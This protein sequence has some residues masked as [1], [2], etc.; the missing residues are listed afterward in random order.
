MRD[1]AYLSGDNVYAVGTG[2]NV[3]VSASLSTGYTK[4]GTPTSAGLYAVAGVS[5]SVAAAVGDSISP[6][7]STFLR[8]N[9][10]CP[11]TGT[12]DA[13]PDTGTTNRLSSIAGPGTSYWAVGSAGTIR[14]FNG[15]TWTAQS[16]PPATVSPAQ[17][18]ANDGNRYALTTATS[19]GAACA[20]PAL[21]AT[22]TVPARSS[23]AVTTPTVKVT[24]GYTFNGSTNASQVSLSTNGGS[25]WSGVAA[26][27]SNVATATVKTVDV[28]GAVPASDSAQQIQLCVQGAGG[29]G[30]M[31]V[32]MVH[33]DV[34]E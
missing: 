19:L 22:A 6:N 16:S 8:C 27:T 21:V 30:R 33:I 3:Y 28:T 5:Q 29:G 12:W 17:L 32:D 14:Y 7:S 15:T 31:N 26:L 18:Q 20:T 9:S 1:V 23:S 10:N 2:G 13:G 24:V 34:D 25:T 4:K 11:S